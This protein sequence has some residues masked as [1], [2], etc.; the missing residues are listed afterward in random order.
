MGR[1]TPDLDR[2]AKPQHLPRHASHGAC[3]VGPSWERGSAP[4]IRFEQQS[5]VFY[6]QESIFET[7]GCTLINKG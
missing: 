1:A 4:F 7:R 3:G 2:G 5:H 6:K